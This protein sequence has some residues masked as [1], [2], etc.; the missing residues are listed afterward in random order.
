MDDAELRREL[1]EVK[2][3]L[4]LIEEFFRLA[5]VSLQSPPLPAAPPPERSNG[6]DG[7]MVE[8]R[9]LRFVAYPG[10]DVEAIGDALWKA[11][12]RGDA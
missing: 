8:H 10:D 11:V 4:D 7:E 12:H 9:G 5:G 2:A 1:A 6:G 3:R